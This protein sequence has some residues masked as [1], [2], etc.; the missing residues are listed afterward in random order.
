M[1]FVTVADP[2]AGQRAR[3]DSGVD[4]RTDI[5]KVDATPRKNKRHCDRIPSALRTQ[6]ARK[7]A[8]RRRLT[9]TEYRYREPRGMVWSNP[10]EG[11]P[12]HRS[13]AHSLSVLQEMFASP[14]KNFC[15]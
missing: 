7:L 14:G 8:G 6:S 3:H 15:D 1:K 12:N 10:Y 5:T 2:F 9:P 11:P 4:L 13:R